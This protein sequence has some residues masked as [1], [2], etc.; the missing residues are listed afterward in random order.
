MDGSRHFNPLVRHLQNF[1]AVEARGTLPTSS[2]IRYHDIE[3]PDCERGTENQFWMQKEG[4][5][6]S[7]CMH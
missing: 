1:C 5:L 6:I 2:V 4:E 3:T 7:A